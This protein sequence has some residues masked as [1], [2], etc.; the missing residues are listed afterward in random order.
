LKASYAKWVA[1]G[2]GGVAQFGKERLKIADPET[3]IKAFNGY[4]DKWKG[5]LKSTDR[6]SDAAILA[7]LKANLFDKL[8][9]AKFGM[10]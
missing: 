3:H 6:K 2:F 5:L 1:D 8:D 4:L 7:V 9:P 10:E